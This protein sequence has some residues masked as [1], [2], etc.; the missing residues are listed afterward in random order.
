MKKS[1]VTV[2]CVC[3]SLIGIWGCSIDE[4]NLEENIDTLEN[5]E[6]NSSNIPIPD[7]IRNKVV[8]RFRDTT[9]STI[10]KKNKRQQIEQ[11]YSFNILNKE[12]CDCDINGPELWT[13]DTTHNNFLGVRHL[14]ENLVT[15][16][17]SSQ[18]DE[19]VEGDEHAVYDY[20][21]YITIANNTLSGN[22][23]TPID[24]R[25]IASNNPDYVNIAILDT[26]VDY[27]FFSQPFLYNTRNERNG[28]FGVSGWDY[29][30]HDKD[31]RDDNGHGSKV[32][33]IITTELNAD[34]VPHQILPI[35][36]FGQDGS[37]SYF[38]IVCGMNYVSKIPNIH[39]VNMSFGWYG[40]RNQSI[41]KAIMQEIS[42]GT[43]FITSAGNYGVNVD[44]DTP[45]FPSGYAIENLLG[46]GGYDLSLEEEL[47]IP[48]LLE[49][50]TIE[51]SNYG[52][53]TIDLAAPMDNYTLIMQSNPNITV[54]PVGTSFSSAY[55]TFIAGKLYDKE[56]PSL[57]LY[58]NIMD[59]CHKIPRLQ[60]KIE[61]GN[62]ILKQ[63]R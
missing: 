40:L 3:I 1:I 51:R 12:T 27:D 49:R 59:S 23:T 46:V 41:L 52:P 19:N 26:G 25:I 7:I 20:Q 29:I 36:T 4:D 21:F 43:L 2:A 48:D 33:K 32:T 37:G 56:V 10:D 42:E 38:D 44:E 55:V 24:N 15:N 22:Y 62:V 34:G 30:N 35:K 57:Q 13:I 28:T 50:I 61:E 14:V 6:K 60:R 63:T 8:V 18:G 54:Y 31:I 53:E 47:D 5:I 39:I 58:S 45:H 16:D 9:L 17:P 11:L